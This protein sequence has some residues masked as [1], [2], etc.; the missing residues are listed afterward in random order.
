MLLETGDGNWLAQ[1]RRIWSW[2][3][4]LVQRKQ[5][6]GV[7]ASPKL[8]VLMQILEH[9]Q[10]Q[11]HKVLVFS[12]YTQTLDMIEKFLNASLKGLKQWRIA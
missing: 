7:D 3:S 4:E 11:G 6:F 5:T 12:Q 9:A 1:E 10:S 8:L 2:A